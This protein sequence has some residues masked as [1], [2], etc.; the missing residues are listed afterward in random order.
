VSTKL[1]VVTGEQLLRALLRAKWNV[2]RTRGSH[3]RLVRDDR[4][5]SVPVHAGRTIPPGTLKGILDD[6]GMT[7]DEL[8]VLL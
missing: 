1:P 7:A 2:V 8:R 6:V 3:V 5:T 4:K